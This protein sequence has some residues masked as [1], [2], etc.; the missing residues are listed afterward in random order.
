MCEKKGNEKERNS[1]RNIPMRKPLKLN[2]ACAGLLLA[3]STGCTTLK[4]QPHPALAA[5]DCPEHDTKAGVAVGIRPLTDRAES[6]KYFGT[7]LAKDKMLAVAVI[8]ENASPNSS[9]ILSRERVGLR[10]QQYAG[11]AAARERVGSS[12]T[13]KALGWAAGGLILAAP[14]LAIP[15]IIGAAKQLSDASIVRHNFLVNELYSTTLRPGGRTQGFLY[16]PLSEQRA[17]P[18]DC[19]LEL[20]LIETTT[21]A[22]TSFRLPVQAAR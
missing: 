9:F 20:D 10:S 17:L 1:N 5:K 8:V 6:K 13:G 14:A 2:L 12:S 22:Q 19:V 7:D 18:S 3:V 16:F 4:I 15:T 21:R 11:D